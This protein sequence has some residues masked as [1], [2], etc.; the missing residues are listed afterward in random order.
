MICFD[1][2][3]GYMTENATWRLLHF[4]ATVDLSHAP[5]T[6]EPQHIVVENDMFHLLKGATKQAK[7]EESYYVWQM[8][9]IAFYAL[10]GIQPFCEPGANAQTGQAE[11][12]YIGSSHCGS[13][14][15]NLIHQC[16]LFEPSNRPRLSEIRLL[17][18]ENIDK[19]PLPKK[20]I[21][22]SKG[23][24]YFNSLVNF[25]PEEMSTLV[26]FICMMMCPNRACAQNDIPK[27]MTAIISR[28]KSLRSSANVNRVSREFLYDKE[29]TLM[30]KIDIDRRGECTVNDKV[31]MFGV[32]DIG[33]RIAKLKSG[34]TNTGGRFRDGQDDRYKYSF[35]EITIKRN[36]SVSYEITGRQGLQQFAVLPYHNTSAFVVSVTKGGK[37]FGKTIMKDGTCYVQL[38]KKVS[39][40]DKFQLSI[41][42]NTGKNMAFVIVNHNPGR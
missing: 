1:E 5:L 19:K 16:M 41:R 4:L 25:W 27:E 17:V 39:K 23:K 22:N 21:T 31:A 10:M 20:K 33:Y 42:N 11:V 2:I 15:S 28:C 7:V 40:S 3:A 32:N 34:V 37:P 29:W 26:L 35:I 8:G 9:C 14:L 24:N 30:D 6:L 13:T 12:P 36:M 38:D 18:A